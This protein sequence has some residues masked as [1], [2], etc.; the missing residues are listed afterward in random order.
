[1][2][3]LTEEAGFEPARLDRDYNAKATV[4]PEAFAAEM[5]RYR[6]TSIAPRADW[7]RHFDVVYDEESGQRIDI[8][9]PPSGADRVRSSCL[10]MAVTGA[11][12]QRKIPP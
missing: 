7:G 4:S 2:I 1:M 12:Y 8:F 3:K 10:F 11:R 9:G 6:E 5:V